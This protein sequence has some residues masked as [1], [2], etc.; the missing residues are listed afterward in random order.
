MN[1]GKRCATVRSLSPNIF[2][3]VSNL[4]RD[5]VL[6]IDVAMV[7][8][9]CADRRPCEAVPIHA[10]QEYVATVHFDTTQVLLGLLMRWKD[11]S[12]LCAIVGT[13]VQIFARDT[14]FGMDYR[15]ATLA[16]SRNQ[17]NED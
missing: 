5:N 17:A 13:S 1:R 9:T 8:I 2:R 14:T 3:L 6:R 11:D 10:H 7:P 15:T 16:T 12:S 4:M